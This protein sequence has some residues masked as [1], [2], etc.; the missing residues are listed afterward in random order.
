MS[1]HKNSRIHDDDDYETQN[2][3]SYKLNL[4]EKSAKQ[5]MTNVNEIDIDNFPFLE[6]YFSEDYISDLKNF[7][8]LK[9]EFT[10]QEFLVLL[11]PI[12]KSLRNISKNTNNKTL[13]VYIDEWKK[14][15]FLFPTIIATIEFILNHKKVF[16]EITY[17]LKHF[18]EEFSENDEDFDEDFEE[19][20]DEEIADEENIDEEI[21]EL[22]NEFDKFNDQE[23]DEEI[24]D[25]IFLDEEKSDAEENYTEKPKQK[26]IIEETLKPKTIQKQTTPL[27][28]IFKTNLVLEQ[29][30]IVLPQ[31]LFFP[32]IV[33]SFLDKKIGFIP[34]TN[35]IKPIYEPIEGTKTEKTD[36]NFAPMKKTN[37]RDGFDRY[38]IELDMGANKRGETKVLKISHY[39]LSQDE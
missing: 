12:A 7:E 6:K 28:D 32:G 3:S 37:L 5:Y 30:K 14:Y 1:G 13:F 20:N 19:F 16:G 27:K 34:K 10:K 11:V 26:I 39:S 24:I 38:V 17:T 2:N 29:T 33:P 9:K 8:K 22:E 15:Y 23:D 31:K 4:V 25:D 21:D 35:Y 36:E 18:E